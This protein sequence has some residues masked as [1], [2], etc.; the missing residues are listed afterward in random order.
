MITQTFLNSPEY[1]EFKEFLMKERVY[2]PI[3]I[4]TRDR[5]NEVIAREVEA[6]AIACRLINTTIKK[7]EQQALT[8]VKK[9]ETWK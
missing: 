6:H 5:S 2:N 8:T 4:K 1:K 3:K 9:P 7:F